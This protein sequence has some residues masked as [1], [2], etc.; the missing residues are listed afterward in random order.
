MTKSVFITGTST[1]VGKTITSRF[2]L[3]ALASGNNG[4]TLSYF[5]PI[6][7]GDEE[8]S[9]SKYISKHCGA[10]VNIIPESYSF[11][12][13]ASPDRAAKA[14]NQTIN[15]EKIKSDF[16]RIKSDYCVIEGAG[17]L[18]VPI[19]ED[20]KILDIAKQLSIPVIIVASTALGTINHTILT[21]ESARANGL[22]ILG[23][24]ISGKEDPG[25]KEIIEKETNLAVIAEIPL[26]KNIDAGL[27]LNEISKFFQRSF[28]EKFKSNAEQPIKKSNNDHIWY[29]FTQHKIREQNHHVVRGEGAF[30]YMD[31]GH[32]VYDAISSWWVNLHGHCHP[33]I[34]EAITKQSQKLEHTILSGLSHGPA[35]SL[36]EKL[37]EITSDCGGDFEKVFFSDNGSTSVEI[38]IKLAYQFHKNKG[39]ERR[40]Y[41]ALKGGYHGDT[42]GAM[43]VS[44]PD[45][46]HKVFKELMFDVDFV[47]PDDFDQLAQLEN[48]SENEYAAFI[49]E[50]LIQG[51]EGMK[52]YSEEYLRKIKSFCSKNGILLIF[53]EVFTGFGRLGHLFA[54]ERAGVLPDMLCLAKGISGGFLP[55]AA[56]LVNEK[57]YDAFL[58]DRIDQAFL[59]GHSYTGNPIAAAASLASIEILTSAE[60]R[61]SIAKIED[62]TRKRIER[63]SSNPKLEDTR[64]IGTIGAIT[65]KGGADYFS[66]DFAYH[67]FEKAFSKGVLLRP[68][69]NVIYTVPPYC[70]TIE[71]INFTYDVIEELLHEYK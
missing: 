69:G 16:T 26:I 36:A 71:D 62:I 67:F 22:N 5:K 3:Q 19:N 1:D 37:I 38:A 57:I 42:C 33:K 20:H 30:L 47:S 54:F 14:E 24:V 8:S 17:G 66:S 65:I 48:G 15:L 23:I 10:A 52:I 9:D 6:Q 35:K 50:P 41:L 55:I 44:D 40:K 21:V 45:G 4:S 43:S 64:S 18:Q 11:K 31:N 27:S 12:L 32:K 7:S 56:T 49:V 53:D 34:V 59:H 39:K 28:I 61:S 63:L 60:C 29:P 58:S 2:L 13:P 25:L 46:F 70:S 68:L 51:A